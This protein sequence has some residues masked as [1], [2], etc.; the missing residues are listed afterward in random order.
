[1]HYF[2]DELYLLVEWY[3]P[4]D[5]DA[6]VGALARDSY[7]RSVHSGPQLNIFNPVDGTPGPRA[8]LTDK[9]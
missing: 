7:S 3:R 1:M 9:W 5:V 2:V 6:V 4:L 8:A